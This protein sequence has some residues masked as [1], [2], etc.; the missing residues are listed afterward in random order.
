MAEVTNE[1]LL[2]LENLDEMDVGGIEAAP[3]FIEPP[4]GRYRLGLQAKVEKYEKDDES[5]RRVRFIYN[6]RDVVELK[7]KTALVPAEGSL[8]SETFTVTP[9]GLKYW[10][11]KAMSI[12]GELGTATFGEVMNEL[13]KGVSFLAD[14]KTKQTTGKDAEGNKKEFTNVQVRVISSDQDPEL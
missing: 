6:I 2:D 14:V 10:K 5:K 7:D 3:E 4:V 8:F 1:T 9:E 12:L 13:N 11:S